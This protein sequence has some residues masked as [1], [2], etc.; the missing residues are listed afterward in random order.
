MED[1]QQKLVVEFP[2]EL[3]KKAREFFTVG[4]ETAYTLNYDYAIEMYLD[5]LSFWPDATE[6]GH[7][8]LREVAL[9]RQQSGGK[10]SGFGD[11]SKYK[12]GGKH[13]KDAMLKAEYL[14]SKDPDN[15]A[16]MADM[17]K[18]A[19]EGKF[20]QA[21]NWISEILYS[22]N[23][24]S[25]KPSFTTYILL[26]DNYIKIENYAKAFNMCQLA[27][28]L[29]PKDSDL[30][31]SLHDLS[32]RA[33]VQQ[34][35]YDSEGD[36][37]DS[38]KDKDDQLKQHDKEQLVLSDDRTASLI[39]DARSEYEAEPTV[40][41]KINKLVNTLCS[42][43]KTENEN[44]AVAI[45]E[46][47]VKETGQFRFQQQANEIRIKQLR[48]R[49]R[50]YNARWKAEPDNGDHKQKASEAVRKL[51]QIEIEHY[52]LCIEKYPTD[53]GF[54]NEYGK[55]LR[56]A[57][58]FDEAIPYFQE[59]RN[60]PRFRV[61]A[62]KNIGQ[63]FFYKGWYPDAIDSFNTALAAVENTEGAIAKELRY[64][65]GRSYEVD[66]NLEEALSEFRKVAQIDYNYQDVRERV[67]ALRKK[68][69]E[70]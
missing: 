34:G 67:D 14:F 33:T 52:K 4:A 43:E 35:N 63:C 41:G 21:A 56:Q 20:G 51:L 49:A 38:I 7:L 48:R 40:P 17:V 69:S 53:N 1:V 44:E 9:R 2:E 55:R 54:K 29:K 39:A 64:N 50:R 65:L 42:T 19:A 24:K 8:K 6:E 28:Q 27:V 32:A 36:F 31:D 60:D 15:M 18:A 30:L 22:R 68:Q 12:K 66:N 13:P 61:E 10:K 5:G 11:G 26:R 3:K 58:K 57:K 70:N 46:K 23:V 45:L 62:L 16:H 37:R 25:E 47:A 59:A